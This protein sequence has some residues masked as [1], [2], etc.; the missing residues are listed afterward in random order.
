V[1]R[2]VLLTGASRGIGAATARLAA[3]RGY[4]VC[5]NYHRQAD[6]AR[7]VVQDVVAAGRLRGA[8]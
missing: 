5:V 3:S 2:I 8:S 6:A 1:S 4:D 7:A